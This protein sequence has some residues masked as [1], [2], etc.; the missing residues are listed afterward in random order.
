MVLGAK[1]ANTYGYRDVCCDSI[2]PIKH[3]RFTSYSYM[4]LKP[5]SVIPLDPSFLLFRA[6]EKEFFILQSCTS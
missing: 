2:G 6:S 1:A 5:A 4:G 3:G